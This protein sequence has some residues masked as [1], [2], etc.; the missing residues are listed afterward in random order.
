MRTSRADNNYCSI[1]G[2]ECVIGGQFVPIPDQLTPDNPEQY[3]SILKITGPASAGKV[4]TFTAVSQGREAI[5]D[6]N[7]E[8]HDLT[9]NLGK[10]G[11][12]DQSGQYALKI[13]GGAHNIAVTGEVLSAQTSYANITLGEWSDQSQNVT[14]NISLVGL[15]SAK[16]L[17]AIIANADSSTLQLGKVKLLVWTSVGAKIGYWSKWVIV[18]SGIWSL[19]AK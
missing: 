10:A 17:T 8:A 1:T 3:D 19:F 5:I 18:K 9:I 2:D 6:I 4:Y 11:A 13:K 12:P 14:R 7:N 15:T 16:P